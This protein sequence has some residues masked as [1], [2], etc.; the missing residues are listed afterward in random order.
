MVW[1]CGH[2]NGKVVSLAADTF[3][4]PAGRGSAAITVSRAGGTDGAISFSWWTQS[5]GA[6]AGADFRARAAHRVSMPEGAQE[7][8]LSVSILDNPARRHTELFYVAI[9][10][11][12]GGATLGDTRRAAVF[13]MRP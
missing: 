6:K 11:P 13:I 9:G 7:L 8:K 2:P 1:F 3:V 10:S 5:A 12:Q 4:V